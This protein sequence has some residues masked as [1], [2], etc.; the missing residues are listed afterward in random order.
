MKQTTKVQ[1]EILGMVRP[2][3]KISCTDRTKVCPPFLHET[4]RE[5]IKGEQ[6]SR[7]N[8]YVSLS[9]S[10]LWRV[11]T[12]R[13][14]GDQGHVQQFNLKTMPRGNDADI[15]DAARG[16]KTMQLQIFNQV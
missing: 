4:N 2:E 16:Q 15:L 12:H 13:F 8:C 11:S 14:P 10:F 6:Y 5:I 3:P 1:Q 7:T 9:S